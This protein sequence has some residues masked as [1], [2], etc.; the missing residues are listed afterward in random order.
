MSVG[1]RQASSRPVALSRRELLRRGGTGLAGAALLGTAAGS[2]RPA[3]AQD[4]T[5]IVFS[6]A[7]DESGSMQNLL[8]AFNQA[9]EGR[10]RVS[11]REMPTSTDEYR[12]QLESDFLVGATDIDVIGGDVIW[13]A[14]FA[15]NGWIRDLTARFFDAYDVHAFL[16]APAN[17]TAFRNRIWAVPWFTDAGMLYYRKDLLEQSGFQ[18]PPSTWDELKQMALRAKQDAGIPY[19][20]V[21]QAAEYEGG[22]TNALEYIW[23]AGG[24]VMTTNVSVAGAFGMVVMD[25]N[26]ITVDNPGAAQ[27][28]NIAHSLIVEGVAPE[29]VTDFTEQESLDVFLAGDAVFMRNWPFAYGVLQTADGAVDPEQVGIAP[30]PVAAPGRPSY[31]CLGG[32]NLM[33]NSSSNEQDAA[34][35]FIRFATSPEAQKQRALQ[36]GFLPT[37][38]ELYEDPEI[39][40]QVPVVALGRD[41][42][43]D[44]RTR[45]ISPFY[46][47][48]SPRIA[49]AFKRVL[50]GQLT[51]EE[52]VQRLER[53][54]RLILRH[55]R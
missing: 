34:W 18:S 35:E 37:L 43:A 12:R 26:V 15:Y 7:P 2:S 45:P 52:A 16:E 36:G 48:M 29:Q 30:I 8:D 27:G 21:F 14:G 40:T 23:S 54:L 13:T 46:Y 19:G 42:I 10:I 55:N 22:V 44:A 50:E 4:A 9:H 53:E 51:G 17:S 24:R 38:R 28:L 11:W 41:A 1:R 5:D 31:S 25:P 6:F 3:A 33:I 47:Q 39:I 20:F 32:W 49:F